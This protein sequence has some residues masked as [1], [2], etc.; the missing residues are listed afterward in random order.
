MCMCVCVWS[1]ARLKVGGFIEMEKTRVFAIIAG[2]V[3][4]LSG[5]F[6]AAAVISVNNYSCAVAKTSYWHFL[7]ERVYAEF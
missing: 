3:Q 6:L 7:D 2:I 4:T 5:S 1:I